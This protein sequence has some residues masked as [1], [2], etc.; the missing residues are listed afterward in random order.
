[1]CPISTWIFDCGAAL[2]IIG[3]VL[4]IVAMAGAFHATRRHA[5]PTGS[6]MAG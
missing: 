4:A 2:E 3:T 1:M 5:S 6:E